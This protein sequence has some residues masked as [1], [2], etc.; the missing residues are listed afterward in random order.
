[1]TK[2]ELVRAISHETGI[3][4]PTAL[5][6]V[7]ALMNIIKETMASGE[8]VYLRGFGTFNLKKRALKV[9]TC[10]RRCSDRGVSPPTPR[11][12]AP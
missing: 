11:E 4:Q 7:E 2:Q 5:A 9:A 12:H 1:M 6:S 3:D 10:A 8:N